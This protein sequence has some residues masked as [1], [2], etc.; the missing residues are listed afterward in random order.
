V[1]VGVSEKASESL[2]EALSR[3][4]WMMNAQGIANSLWGLMLM[5]AKWSSFSSDLKNTVISA[6]RRELSTMSEQELSNTLYAMGTIGMKYDAFPDH[7]HMGL[8]H[9][10]E[11]RIVHMSPNGVIMALAGF[12][13]LGVKHKYMPVG[14][15]LAFSV[16]MERILLKASERT[17]SSLVLTLS[18]VCAEWNDLSPSLQSAF[19]NTMQNGGSSELQDQRKELKPEQIK[20][21]VKDGMTMQSKRQQHK[22]EKP[23]EAFQP[24]NQTFTDV[25][26]RSVM[27]SANR[28]VKLSNTT[29]S[30]IAPVKLGR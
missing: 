22:G 9:T 27:G 6:V 5:S 18:S 10:I 7:T 11:N 20:P 24:Q 19:I 8:L 13:K 15:K 16:A 30:S 23:K 26:E 28:E 1:T 4:G 2:L 12:G 21:Q 29:T 25:K 14:L 17:I 3:E